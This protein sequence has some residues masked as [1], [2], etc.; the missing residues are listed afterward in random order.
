MQE[1]AVSAFPVVS[2]TET[3]A[4]LIAP[5]V[6]SNVTSLLPDVIAEHCVRLGQSTPESES[7]T[8]ICGVVG[9]P[10][11]VNPIS[12]LWLST[13]AQ[14]FPPSGHDTAMSGTE[15]D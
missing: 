7:D 13:A 15:F 5:V 6:G 2:I 8:M 9:A 14:E 11:G 3:P 10:P 1:I 4:A 12:A